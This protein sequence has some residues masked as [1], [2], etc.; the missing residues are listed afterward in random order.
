MKYEAT[1]IAAYVAQLPAERAEAVEKLLAVVNENIPPGFERAMSYNMPGFVVSKS[2]YP[3][4]YHAKP[5]EP[6]PFI[7]VASQKNHVAFYHMGFG[8]FPET[9]E[10]FVAEYGKRMN[11]KLDMGKGCIR[12]RDPKTIPFALI[13]ELASKIHAKEYIARYES[14]IQKRQRP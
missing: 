2:A 12:F 10:W 11:T 6:L 3:A 4:G 14:A 8:M 7:G 1:D 9:L 13:G 5:Q